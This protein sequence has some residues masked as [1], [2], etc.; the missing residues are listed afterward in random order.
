[1]CGG[2]SIDMTDIFHL[3]KLLGLLQYRSSISE[4]RGYTFV[5]VDVEKFY[6]I[7]KTQSAKGK[8]GLF[9]VKC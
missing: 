6:N 3:R 2:D 8:V 7:K 4:V 9:A 5:K 1:M